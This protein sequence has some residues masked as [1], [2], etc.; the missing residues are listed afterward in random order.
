MSSN[1]TIY[2]NVA[3]TVPVYIEV[4]GG[5]ES[6]CLSNATGFFFTKCSR[7]FLVT[8]CHVVTGK[9]GETGASLHS[10]SVI[11]EILKVYQLD[12]EAQ[13]L[14]IWKEIALHQDENGTR[15]S[16]EEVQAGNGSRVWFEHPQR[17][18]QVDIAVIRINDTKIPAHALDA[19][20]ALGPGGHPLTNMYQVSDDV[21]VI[22]YPI[23]KDRGMIFPVWKRA[24]ICYE[25][26]HQP[27]GLPVIY[28]DTAT[29]AGMS[30]SPA[31]FQ[32]INQDVSTNIEH[33]ELA[34]LGV[35]SGRVGTDEEKAQLGIVWRVTALMDI[36]NSIP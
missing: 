35:Y 24:S 36:V 1:G 11:P 28:L 7:T 4:W 8:N 30:G 5:V 25:P 17:G 15:V 19:A 3:S 34:F 12:S 27:N 18:A 9:N 23:G 13:P 33:P 32:Y 20:L 29:R 26:Q 14:T 10:G 22:G 21:Q 31:F 2:V 6:K 16:S